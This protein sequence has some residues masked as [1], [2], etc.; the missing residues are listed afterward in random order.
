MRITSSLL[1]SF[2]VHEEHF[3][4]LEAEQKTAKEQ[5]SG[6]TQR[7]TEQTPEFTESLFENA[8]QES[9]H[10]VSDSAERPRRIN[11]SVLRHDQPEW[12]AGLLGR[13]QTMEAS[14]AA[15][16]GAADLRPAVAVTDP[17][18]EVERR[19]SAL[20]FT[21]RP[22]SAGLDCFGIWG[23]ALGD[24]VDGPCQDAGEGFGFQEGSE[25]VTQLNCR[26]ASYTYSCDFVCLATAVQRQKQDITRRLHTYSDA[27][28]LF[29]RYVTQRLRERVFHTA[30]KS[31]IAGKDCVQFVR[32]ISSRSSKAP[33]AWRQFL[34][35]TLENLN[36]VT[37]Q[38]LLDWP[39]H[40]P[41]L[42]EKDQVVL[43]RA[44][45]VAHPPEFRPEVVECRRS[46]GRR[47]RQ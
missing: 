20:Q 36:L 33:S 7:T 40:Y 45:R 32:K 26:S 27:T 28:L 23:V 31:V 39:K 4:A 21:R 41:A 29:V 19:C 10:Q 11:A 14:I 17:P 34:F 18:T 25:V 15:L 37:G 8:S 46:R 42:V 44:F 47:A 24:R 3:A 38:R 43:S 35:P 12:L 9:G 5:A 13:L 1:L 22:S 16:S 6:E 2:L 30:M